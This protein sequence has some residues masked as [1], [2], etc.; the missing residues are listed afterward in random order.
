MNQIRKLVKGFIEELFPL[1]F[2]ACAVVGS[3]H[4][5]FIF[6]SRTTSLEYGRVKRRKEF[7]N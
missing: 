5:A 6:V 7:S 3:T 1:G 4:G 2:A